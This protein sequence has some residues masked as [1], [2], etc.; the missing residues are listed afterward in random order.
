MIY[1]QK[2]YHITCAF[3]KYSY[4]NI[5]NTENIYI[6]IG[7][8]CIHADHI[9]TRISPNF[10]QSGPPAGPPGPRGPPGPSGTPGAD[11]IDVSIMVSG[12][13]H[14]SHPVQRRSLCAQVFAS[15]CSC[16]IL[17]REGA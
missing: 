13:C 12:W 7:V 10:F 9:Y 5:L 6:Y 14:K 16:T 15:L 8:R 2:Y 11:G 17:H 1:Y 3:S 4:R